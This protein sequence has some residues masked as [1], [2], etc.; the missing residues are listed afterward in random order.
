[1]SINASLN[2]VHQFLIFQVYI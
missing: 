2:V 1:M